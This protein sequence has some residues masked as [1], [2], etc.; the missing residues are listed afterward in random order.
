M[1]S[2]DPT[3]KQLMINKVSLHT[4][5]RVQWAAWLPVEHPP[6]E[7]VKSALSSPSVRVAPQD[8][9]SHG[10]R[11]HFCLLLPLPLG[12]SD[13]RSLKKRWE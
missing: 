9:P 4:E 7:E 3:A 11:L 12:V 8:R 6:G 13:A 1:R 2:A 5:N 10:Y